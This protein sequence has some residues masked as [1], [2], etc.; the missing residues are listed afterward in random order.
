[1]KEFEN[2]V[3]IQEL[4]QQINAS[5]LFSIFLSK[6]QRKQR[7][8]IEEQLN[9]LLNQMRLFSERFSPLGWCM[10]DSMSVPLIEKANQVYETGGAEAAEHILIDYYKGE[11]KDR[12]HQIHHKSKELLLRYELI[13]NAFEEHFAERYYA[14]VPLFLIIVDGAVND[15]SLIHI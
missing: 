9:S 2:L 4:Q 1:M 14:S 3:S 11:V 12:I 13:K 6:E 15:L 7:K 5:K 8:E 10:Y